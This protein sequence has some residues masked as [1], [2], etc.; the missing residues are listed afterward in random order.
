MVIAGAGA[1]RAGQRRQRRALVAR[2][3]DELRATVHEVIA[4]DAEHR[5]SG[6]C[7]RRSRRAQFQPGPVLP[8]AELRVA[9]ADAHGTRTG[10]GRPG[11]DRRLGRSRARAAVDHRAGNGRLRPICARCCKPGE[12]VV[13]MGPTGT[14]TNRTRAKPCCW[15]AAASATRCCS[16]SAQAL[17][18]AG[19]KVLVLRRLQED[20]RPLQGRRDRS[21]GR[22]HRLVLR[23]SARLRRHP[24]AGQDLRRQHR[25]GDG[26]LRQRQ[27]GRATDRHARQSTAS[28]PSAR[29]A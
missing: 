24:R 14:P 17:R 6:A 16:R 27:A 26:G 23:R 3:N 11:A 22:R 15:S 7:R 5:R 1:A 29:T 13:L 12:P 18:A 4:S 8:A 10:D 28:S 20:H 2:L 25:R 9:G 21:G 19:S